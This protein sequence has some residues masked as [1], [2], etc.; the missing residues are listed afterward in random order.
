MCYKVIIC[1]ILDTALE[2]LWPHRHPNKNEI[3]KYIVCL[4]Y[5]VSCHDVYSI[6]KQGTARAYTGSQSCR[7]RRASFHFMLTNFDSFKWTTDWTYDILSF[8]T[9]V[10]YT[11]SSNWLCFSVHLFTCFYKLRSVH[12]DSISQRSKIYL[13]KWTVHLMLHCIKF[14]YYWDRKRKCV[15]VRYILTNMCCQSVSV[16]TYQRLLMMHNIGKKTMFISDN[17]M[18]LRKKISSPFWSWSIR[19]AISAIVET[20]RQLHTV[21]SEIIKGGKTLYI[22]TQGAR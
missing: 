3:K 1:Q 17:E 6:W 7:I 18:D 9:T 13:I 21:H 10:S 4:V 16:T 11:M 19:F 8:L 5:R 12:D 20:S 14:H 15:T 22:Y 2:D